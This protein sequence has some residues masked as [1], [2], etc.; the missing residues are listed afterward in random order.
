MIG[1][2]QEHQ[3]SYISAASPSHQIIKLKKKSTTSHIDKREDHHLWIIIINNWIIAPSESVLIIS[4]IFEIGKM[5][6][7][8]E[9][10]GKILAMFKNLKKNLNFMLAD[11]F[12][13]IADKMFFGPSPIFCRYRYYQHCSEYWEINLAHQAVCSLLLILWSK[14]QSRPILVTWLF[15]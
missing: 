13:D 12:A 15:R 6:Y 9:N 10:I 3:G 8:W 7:R 5:I 11:I 1:V 14:S 4:A 2:Y